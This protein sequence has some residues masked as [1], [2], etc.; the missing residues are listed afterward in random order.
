MPLVGD[1]MSQKFSTVF[2]LVFFFFLQPS[3][4]KFAPFEWLLLS[5]Q[6]QPQDCV[7]Q[8]GNAAPSLPIKLKSTNE[9]GVRHRIISNILS[10]A[11]AC[12]YQ[13]QISSQIRALKMGEVE[14][15]DSNRITSC[16]RLDVS[17]QLGSSFLPPL[18]VWSLVKFFIAEL[19]PSIFISLR[20]RARLS[21]LISLKSVPACSIFDNVAWTT[22]LINEI[23]QAEWKRDGF[24]SF[25]S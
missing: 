9:D 23:T 18:D 12:L 14:L 22:L 3:G 6:V 11:Q 5:V 21:R 4:V 10:H 13:P 15:P 16:R 24:D 17:L 1:C 20:K 19:R 7:P 2:L 8:S 25:P